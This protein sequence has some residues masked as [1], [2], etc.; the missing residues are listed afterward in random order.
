MDFTAETLSRRG[1]RKPKSKPEIAEGAEVNCSC[2]R[3]PV[4]LRRMG[5]SSHRRAF[6]DLPSRRCGCFVRRFF[7][8]PRIHRTFA[9]RNQ[10]TSALSAHS[11]V[12]FSF[13]KPRR[14]GVSAVKTSFP[15]QSQATS[16]ASWRMPRR[17]TLPGPS[18]G[19]SPPS[20]PAPGWPKKCPARR[21]PARDWIYAAPSTDRA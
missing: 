18:R 4:A 7:S 15:F 5:A 13:L 1:F 14:L 6:R 19:T 3:I 11:G 17:R 12:D 21:P 2:T 10:L 16:L 20:P 8:V 9:E